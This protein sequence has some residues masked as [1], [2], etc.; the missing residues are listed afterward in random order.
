MHAD[1]KINIIMVMKK[2]LFVFLFLLISVVAGFSQSRNFLINELSELIGENDLGVY[3]SLGKLY[4]RS[5]DSEC[6][7]SRFGFQIICSPKLTKY[8]FPDLI[9]HI[10][11][12]TL[13]FSVKNNI[14][15]EVYSRM[16]LNIE[17]MDKILEN[18]SLSENEKNIFKNFLENYKINLEGMNTD[19]YVEAIIRSV[20]VIP[21]NPA[22]IIKE[23]KDGIRK[24]K[25]IWI[26]N[27]KLIEYIKRNDFL[28][29]E[30]EFEY[31]NTHMHTSSR[32]IGDY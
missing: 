17:K 24:V 6:T 27:Y 12:P 9:K 8:S 22:R 15:V 31:S 21:V 29:I 7:I 5:F 2:I 26:K 1:K 20:N 3:N 30:C 16:A 10:M 4:N 18:T 23:E 25:F 28:R 13:T 32:F 14:I 19:E 11:L